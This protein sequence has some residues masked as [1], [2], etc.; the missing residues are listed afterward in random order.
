VLK[1]I[2]SATAYT[3]ISD[4]ANVPYSIDFSTVGVLAANNDEVILIS[5]D[6]FFGVE[7]LFDTLFSAGNISLY[8]SIGG[9]L[10]SSAMTVGNNGLS[11][12]TSDFTQ[13]RKITWTT[14]VGW[15]S[16]QLRYDPGEKTHS[17]SLLAEDITAG[18]TDIDVDDGTD[19]QNNDVIQ[20]DDEKMTVSSIAS[21][22]LTVVRGAYGTAAVAHDDNTKVF[23]VVGI[24]LYKGY[25]IKIKR[26]SATG[27]CELSEAK[28]VLR[29]IGQNEDFLDLELQQ[30]ILTTE[31]VSDEVVI[32]N[33]NETWSVGVWHQN[34][35]LHN[36]LEEIL[37]TCNYG[38]AK[39][40]I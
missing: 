6:R 21:N 11:D 3:D 20:I 30:D 26:N 9:T 16:N 31:N 38:S 1:Y 14:A 39:R 28:K 2:N 32:R 40:V 22:T 5:P 13:D 19:F 27:T 36:L 18:Q 29:C 34:I 23:I 15:S 17:G 37:D 35:S 24:A 4:V 8:Y 33:I 7:L 25:M 10:W 12:G